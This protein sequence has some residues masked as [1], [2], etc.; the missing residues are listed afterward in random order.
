MAFTKSIAATVTALGLLSAP[1]SA[2]DLFGTYG[3]DDRVTMVSYSLPF[4]GSAKTNDEAA[5]ALNVA[6]GTEARINTGF[7]MQSLTLNGLNVMALNDQLNAAEAGSGL[8]PLIAVGFVVG[9]ALLVANEF[10]DD[11]DAGGKKKDVCPEGL[12]P[13]GAGGCV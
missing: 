5:F 10:G 9:G 2:G 6:G 12:V 7:E 8:M 11:D 1:A 3:H 13:D 4:H